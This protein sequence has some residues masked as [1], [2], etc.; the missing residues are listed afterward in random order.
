MY[1]A[2][3]VATDTVNATT[4]LRYLRVA[5]T[6]NV[7][8]HNGTSFTNAATSKSCSLSIPS[9][10]EANCTTLSSVDQPTNG[11]QNENDTPSNHDNSGSDKNDDDEEE[12]SVAT[13]IAV[14]IGCSVGIVAMACFVMFMMFV[15]N[16]C[17]HYDGNNSR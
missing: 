9:P 12:D 2:R 17:G 5:D 3:I 7:S 6:I 11:I 10:G 16:R 1:T 13:V 15:C 14:A 8:L 4:F